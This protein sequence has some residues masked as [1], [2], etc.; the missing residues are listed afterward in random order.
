VIE[1]SK[2]AIAEIR[3]MQTARDRVNSNLRVG[4]A[5]G[6]CENF[7]YTID[8]TDSILEQERVC[9]IEG[10]AVVMERQ[11]LA[12]LDNLKL[13]YAEDLMG[14]GFRFENPLATNVCGCGNSFAIAHVESE[15][16]QLPT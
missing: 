6:G 7:Y 15:R 9:S 2:A 8:L 3:R 1:I 10:I 5:K 4:F 14:G 13:D 11:H 12:Y 16:W